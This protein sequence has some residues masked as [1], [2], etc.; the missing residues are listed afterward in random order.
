M[1][2]VTMEPLPDM[3]IR[4]TKYIDGSPNLGY[5]QVVNFVKE[6]KQ[7]K[8]LKKEQRKQKQSSKG[9]IGNSIHSSSDK[10]SELVSS[11]SHRSLELSQKVLKVKTENGA[12]IFKGPM[13]TAWPTI[14]PPQH[15][16]DLNQE[17]TFEGGGE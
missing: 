10:T 2:A 7:L 11:V 17:G 13:N 14:Q 12:E 4:N 6:N 8:K 1:H 15:E 5:L 9:L 3:R 16:R